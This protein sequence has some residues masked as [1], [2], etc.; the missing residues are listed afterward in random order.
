MKERTPYIRP[1]VLSDLEEVTRLKAEA[2]DVEGAWRKRFEWEFAANPAREADQPLGW[3]LDVGGGRLAGHRMA[4]PQRFKVLNSEQYVRFGVDT[5]CHPDYRGRGYGRQLNKAFFDA[6]EGGLALDTSANAITEHIWLTENAISIGDLNKSFLFPYRSAPLVC[7][8]L[9]RRW[10]RFPAGS[11]VASIAGTIR[12]ALLRRSMPT[13][14]A[15]IKVEPVEPDNGHLDKIWQRHKDE[16]LITVVRDEPYRMWRYLRAPEPVPSLW[17][18]TD[19]V[20]DLQAWFSLRVKLRGI[21][22]QVRV[23]ELLDMFGPAGEPA[24]QRDVLACAV[25]VAKETNADVLEVNGLNP[26]WRRHLPKL[27]FLQRVLPSNPFLCKNMSDIDR[28]I[29]ER[30]ENWHL[31]SADGDLAV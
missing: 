7:E 15:S 13:I 12:D 30:A 10:P 9:L 24:F 19:S 21:E 8:V 2:G 23:C 1:F 14:A 6:Q 18:V 26:N 28:S 3:V 27:G 4:M 25:R 11:F 20:R 22:Q 29:L 5:W 16:Y 31:C 17:L